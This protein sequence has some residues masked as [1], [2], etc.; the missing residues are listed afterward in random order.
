[1]SNSRQSR[2]RVSAVQTWTNVG[3]IGAVDAGKSTLMGYFLLRMGE[4]DR[5]YSNRIFR[6]SNEH[7]KKDMRLA[8]LLDPKGPTREVGRPGAPGRGTI[9]LSH[10]GLIIENK[11]YMIIDSPGHEE[12]IT[13]TIIGVSQANTAILVVECKN[14]PEVAS[15]SQSSRSAEV[16]RSHI[17]AARLFGVSDF[18][19]VITKMD[20]VDFSETRFHEA[21]EIIADTFKIVDRSFGKGIEKPS[22]IV[23]LPTAI[24]PL[25]D[26]PSAY[27]VVNDDLPISW[28]QGPSKLTFFD[29]LKKIE[30]DPIES[31]PL[32]FS[33]DQYYA[34]V[35]G[36]PIVV[37]G[38]VMSGTVVVGED[39]LML[40]INQP[41]RVSSIKMRDERVAMGRIQRWYLERTI[42]PG[43]VIGVGLRTHGLGRETLLRQLKAENHRLL[44][45][46]SGESPSI[47]KRVFARIFIATDKLVPVLGSYEY[48]VFAGAQHT[49]AT[50]EHIYSINSSTI[51]QEHIELQRGDIVDISV[52]FIDGLALDSHQK[53]LNNA[54]IVFLKGNVVVAGG[55]VTRLG[56]K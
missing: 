27:N 26:P 6:L 15:K 50:I 55:L 38:K 39:L 52:L 30:H 29:A 19:V 4:F 23:Y 13:R 17:I 5:A 7:N 34:Q 54:R 22:H 18:I 43:S 48:K 40:P 46:R 49:V 32:R 53:C 41:V 44:L 45:V 37:G 35:M 9:E 28:W 1:M 51:E 33:I 2:D 36:A 10:V 25:T 11:P 42:S 21:V 14:A 16:F 24:L 20:Q 12:F 8:Y 31:G 47:S 3:T 56:E